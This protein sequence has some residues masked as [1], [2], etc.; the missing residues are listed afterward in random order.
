MSGYGLARRLPAY[1]WV[2]AV[3]CGTVSMA[4]GTLLDDHRLPV[5]HLSKDW[6]RERVRQGLA[7][8]EALALGGQTCVSQDIPQDE[9][10]PIARGL[11]L[12]GAR[13]VRAWWVIQTADLKAVVLDGARA[14][15]RRLVASLPDD[16]GTR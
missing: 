9:L 5:A 8:V 16:Q 13:I 6:A 12:R 2:P 10:A 7:Q 14:E 4:D 15:L 11:G 1:R 3:A